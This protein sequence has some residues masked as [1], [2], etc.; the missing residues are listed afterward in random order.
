[1]RA[2][3][4]RQARRAERIATAD[5][6][7]ADLKASLQA[8]RNAYAKQQTADRPAL[9][10]RHRKEDQQFDRAV[11]ARAELDR[12]AEIEARRAQARTLDR[13]RTHDREQGH[14]IHQA[15]S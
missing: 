1:M 6:A 15:V 3:F 13:Q 9:T 14:D 8:E 11:T 10:D 4:D 12:A 5:R 2:D 7:V